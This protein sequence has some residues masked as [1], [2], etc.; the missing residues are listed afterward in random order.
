MS[1]SVTAARVGVRLP[2]QNARM[3][4]RDVIHQRGTTLPR[5]PREEGIESLDSL[6][7]PPGLLPP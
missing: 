7:A 3:R 4:G 1:H 5:V 6:E 2:P